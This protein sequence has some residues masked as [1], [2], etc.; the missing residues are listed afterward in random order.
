MKW[1]LLEEKHVNHDYQ[2]HDWSSTTK[3]VPP[4]GFFFSLRRMARYSTQG[5]ET[6]PVQEQINLPSQWYRLGSIDT[7]AASA[8]MTR[9]HWAGGFLC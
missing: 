4:P 3:P 7:H 8:L 5:L 6:L 2:Q 9:H 1:K